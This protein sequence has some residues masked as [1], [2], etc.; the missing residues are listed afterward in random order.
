M[1][2]PL[3]VARMIDQARRGDACARE[4]LFALTFPVVQAWSR[5]WQR[6]LQK[7]HMSIRDL[8]Q[9]AMLVVQRCFSNFQADSATAW[10]AWVKRIHFRLAVAL[11]RTQSGDSRLEM[12]ITDTLQPDDNRDFFVSKDATPGTAAMIREQSDRVQLVLSRLDPEYQLALKLWLDGETLEDHARI[13]NCKVHQVRYARMKAL[14]EF[15][16]LW[17]NFRITG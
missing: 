16:I 3:E 14:Q 2:E 11:L 12:A 6:L 5:D 9:E 17:N 13:V 1:A 7:R 10:F 8:S 15:N 4:N